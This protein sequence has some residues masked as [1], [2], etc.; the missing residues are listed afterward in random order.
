MSSLLRRFTTQLDQTAAIQSGP[1]EGQFQRSHQVSEVEARE[2]GN[3]ASAVSF[4]D[5]SMH[6]MLDGDHQVQ[7]DEKPCDA[8]TMAGSGKERPITQPMSIP[9]ASQGMDMSNN[10]KAPPS[11]LFISKSLTIPRTSVAS[12]LGTPKAATMA[13]A[14]T[15]RSSL[16]LIETSSMPTPRASLSSR[17]TEGDGSVPVSPRSPKTPGGRRKRQNKIHGLDYYEFCEL[18]RA[19]SL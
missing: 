2:K 19:G 12:I 6:V 15:P 1:E 17:D 14:E 9:N 7:Y 4:N 10:D 5:F 11:P 16:D 18:V 13:A 3:L 8:S